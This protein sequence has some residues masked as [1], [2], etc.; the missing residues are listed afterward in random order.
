VA[1][2]YGGLIYTSTNSG[3]NWQ[4]NVVPV[5]NWNCLASSADGT[6][7]VAGAYND[8][9]YLS[10]NSGLTW[11][12][13]INSPVNSWNAI[14]SSSD[15]I[16]L[17]ATGSGGT[18]FSSDS[19][20]I[21]TT[22]KIAG[23]SVASSANGSKLII[24]NLNANICIST[25]FGVS[26]F[27]NAT[28]NEP[29]SCGA[30]SADGDE[31]VVGAGNNGGLW[32][33]RSIPSPELSLTQSSNNTALS[34]LIPSTNFVVQQSPDLIAWSSVTDQPALNLTNLNYEMNFAPSNTSGFFRL[35]L[36]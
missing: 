28:V 21:W 17:V 11:K 10:T 3:T 4:T 35:V 25:N 15:G 8:Q 33:S 29:F 20:G 22:S 7:L 13:P 31:M 27:T 12:A 9:I 18:C 32:F 1:A 19:G 16:H 14:A 23:V 30:L 26:W 2:V 24:C 36:Q 34:W 6:K 5:K